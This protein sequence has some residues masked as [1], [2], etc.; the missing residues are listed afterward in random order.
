MRLSN[1]KCKSFFCR[2][3]SRLMKL[4]CLVLSCVLIC[5]ITAVRL[6]F[7][8][9]TLEYC[10]KI[11]G[12]TSGT[13]TRTICLHRYWYSSLPWNTQARARAWS[14]STQTKGKWRPDWKYCYFSKPVLR[15]QEDISRNFSLLPHFFFSFQERLVFSFLFTNSIFQKRN[16]TAHF[17]VQFHESESFFTDIALT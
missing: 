17:I 16:Q 10:S 1:K 8:P 7:H 11:T 6:L 12:F 4:L 15:N 3:S 5:S 13:I 14:W 2:F 9:Q